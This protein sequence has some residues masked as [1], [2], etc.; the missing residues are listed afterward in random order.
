MLEIVGGQP[1]HDPQEDPFPVRLRV[2][3]LVLLE[4]IKYGLPIPRLAARGCVAERSLGTSGRA[5]GS[6]PGRNG[7]R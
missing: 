1:Y 4:D 2:K 7:S 3:P 6:A 5:P